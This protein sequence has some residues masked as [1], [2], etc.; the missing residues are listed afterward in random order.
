MSCMRCNRSDIGVIMTVEDNSDLPIGV[1]ICIGGGT[2][3]RGSVVACSLGALAEDTESGIRGGW[4]LGM[5]VGEADCPCNKPGSML[6]VAEATLAEAWSLFLRTR[7]SLP[8]AVG[9]G[10]LEP[11]RRTCGILASMEGL[12]LAFDSDTQTELSARGVVGRR[13]GGVVDEG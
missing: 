3:R 2:R 11:R 4:V 13:A 1:G 8:G 10:E 6:L 12:C 9:T 7:S 5:V